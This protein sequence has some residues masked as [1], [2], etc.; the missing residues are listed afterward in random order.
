MKIEFDAI[1]MLEEQIEA[2]VLNTTEKAIEKYHKK[3]TAKEWMSIKE[4]CE[5]IGISF[6]SFCKL[7]NLGLKVC[8]INAIKRVSKKE[9][10]SFLEKNSY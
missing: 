6:N 7:R 4:A 2:V 8:E 3:N 9:I 5:Y 10:D 1:P